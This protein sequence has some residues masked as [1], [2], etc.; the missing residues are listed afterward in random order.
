MRTSHINIG[1]R[2]RGRF[3][4]TL[5]ELLVVIAII[6]LLVG[7]LLPALARARAVARQVQDA[8]NIRNT[9]QA[10]ITFAQNNQESYPLP[11]RLDGADD[12]LAAG[13]GGGGVSKDNTGNVLSILVFNGAVSTQ[14]AVSPAEANTA[15]V[16][17]DLGYEFAN[18]VAAAVP[19]RA[20]WDPGFAGTP[21]DAESARRLDGGVRV[22]HQSYAQAVPVGRRLGVWSATFATTEAVFGNRGPGYAE[23]VYPNHGRYA[24]NPS[25]AGVPGVDSNSLLIHGGR[26]TWEGNIGYNDGHVTFET[27]PNPDGV[28]Y[29]RM[30]G[31]PLAAPDNLFIDETDEAGSQGTAGAQRRLN[32]F[33]RPIARLTTGGGALTSGS[34]GGVNLWVD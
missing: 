29:R 10:M 20:L 4:F 34:T 19:A 33:L 18:P 16:R 22:A 30:A 26:N 28:T 6:A 24:L 1:E 15:Q 31:Q 21:L 2:G 7:I 23:T 13:G 5:I 11:S 9:V 32:N 27:K 25:G 8:N 3:G 17:P 12:T 14:M